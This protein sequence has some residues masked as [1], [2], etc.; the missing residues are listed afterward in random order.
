M[1]TILRR[2]ILKSRYWLPFYESEANT[3]YD[4]GDVA[5]VYFFLQQVAK[6]S[7]AQPPGATWASL[8][9]NQQA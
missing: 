8:C 1:R 7:M 5:S 9:A 6:Q 3:K 4:S 2:I